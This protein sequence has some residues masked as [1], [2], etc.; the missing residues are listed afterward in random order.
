MSD[1]RPDRLLE[2]ARRTVLPPDVRTLPVFS[3]RRNLYTDATARDVSVKLLGGDTESRLLVAPDLWRFSRPRESQTLDINYRTGALWLRDQHLWR[4]DFARIRSGAVESKRLVPDWNHLRDWLGPLGL[5]PASGEGFDLQVTP[6]WER[7]THFALLRHGQRS[8]YDADVSRSY[9]LLIQLP[10]VGPVA[11]IGTGTKLGVTYDFQGRT[12]GL[13]LG[14]APVA[15]RHTDAASISQIDSDRRFA[16][17]FTHGDAVEFQSHLSYRVVSEPD[18]AA[19]LAPCWVYDATINAAGRRISPGVYMFPATQFDDSLAPS[20]VKKAAKAPSPGIS[21]P[22]PAVGGTATAASRSFVA[23]LGE[24]VNLPFSE[25]TAT[26]IDD[27]LTAAGWTSRV[28]GEATA[29]ETDWQRDAAAGVNAAD[30]AWYVGHAD[31]GAIQ[32]VPPEY[33]WLTCEHC[34]FGGP[35]RWVV[36]DACGP[37]QDQATVPGMNSVF[38]RWSSAFTGLRGL[39]GF[40]TE[41]SP[42]GLQGPAAMHLALSGDPLAQSWFRA[43]C[44]NQPN[45]FPNMVPYVAG[46]FVAAGDKS[47]LDDCLPGFGGMAQEPPEPGN[48]LA[49]WVPLA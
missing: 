24:S 36:V 47:A 33:T 45:T 41:Q 10:A 13:N 30:L 40:G 44:E 25:T 6:A 27:A 17:M 2:R 19:Y 23:W 49:V 7:A 46:M 35:L 4:P 20:I 8:D 3:I 29:I 1:F 16:R 9:S 39:L 38:D 42:Q 32:L 37:L 18:G 31:G 5:F 43:V 22:A 14:W 15:A 26:G 48:F 12:I 34:L 11:A 21:P 28:F